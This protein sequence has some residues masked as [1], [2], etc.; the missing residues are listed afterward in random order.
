MCFSSSLSLILHCQLGRAV[1]APVRTGNLSS[2]HTCLQ[3]VVGHQGDT[4]T[5]CTITALVKASCCKQ[6]KV[7]T[8]TTSL[9]LSGRRGPTWGSNRGESVMPVDLSQIILIPSCL[10]SVRF[11]V[12][13]TT[14]EFSSVGPLHGVTP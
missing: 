3:A 13:S 10:L 6:W 7:I 8:G 11:L 14:A 12:T 2:G 4:I 5:G 1:A 9:Y